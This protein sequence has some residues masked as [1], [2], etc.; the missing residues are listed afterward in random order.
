MKGNYVVFY[1]EHRGY[2]ISNHQRCHISNQHFN[3]H[4]ILLHYQ[5]HLISRHHERHEFALEPFGHLLGCCSRAP[6]HKFRFILSH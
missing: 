1:H 5:P 6:D 2:A 3:S 4:T